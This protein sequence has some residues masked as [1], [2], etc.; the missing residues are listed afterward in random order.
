M[1]K[2]INC[3]LF[4]SI[5]F[6]GITNCFAFDESATQTKNSYIENVFDDGSYIEV[7]IEEYT[8]LERTSTVSGA[9][10]KNY[11][12]SNG[13]IVWSLKVEGKFSYT[14]KSATCTSAS[15]ITNTTTSYWKFSNKSATKSSATAKASVTA[16]KYTVAGV[17]LNTIN[18]SVSL[19]CSASG[20]LS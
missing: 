4:L 2:I 9:K 5:M 14:G 19:T 7:I 17:C 12:D 15:A 16:K 11:K 10:T 20:K 1:K 18:S 8:H 13:K 3:I 6:T